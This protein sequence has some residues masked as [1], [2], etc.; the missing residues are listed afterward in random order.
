MQTIRCVNIFLSIFGYIL[1]CDPKEEN[2]LNNI[3]V[4]DSKGI[5]V[6][7]LKREEKKSNNETYKLNISSIN[8]GDIA[9]HIFITEEKGFLRYVFSFDINGKKYENSPFFK[10]ISETMEII[11]SNSDNERSIEILNRMCLYDRQHHV[12]FEFCSN[13]SNNSICFF[14]PENS[15]KVYCENGNYRYMASN[16]FNN[17]KIMIYQNGQTL[18]YSK[19]IDVNNQDEELNLIE[20]SSEDTP[21]GAICKLAAKIKENNEIRFIKNPSAFIRE[22]RRLCRN[23]EEG[24]NIFN[25]I[26]SITLGEY[27]SSFNESDMIDI[28]GFVP[29]KLP[30]TPII[31]EDG[32]VLLPRDKKKP[33]RKKNYALIETL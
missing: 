4:V 33:I 17:E 15:L 22:F 11:V 28:F 16:S 3:S 21:I 6:G 29:C 10:S 18:G 24:L 8:F 12:I 1:D 23:D 5:I 14:T 13:G 19:N 30:S 20:I 7:Y 9:G 26:A 31:V 2:D 25:N 27:T 32:T